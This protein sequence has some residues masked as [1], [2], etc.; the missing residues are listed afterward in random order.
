MNIYSLPAQLHSILPAARIIAVGVFDGVHIGHRT[1]L[2]RALL[3][4]DLTPAVFTFCETGDL[5]SGGY[6]Q[7]DSER[8]AMLKKL[9]FS[10]VFEA[11]FNAIRDMSPKAFVDMLKNDLGAKAIV[12][13]F[14][15]RF[16]KGGVGDIALLQTLC[17][18]ADIRVYVQ[19]AIEADGKAVSSTR[20][21]QAL[22]AGDM[23]TVLRLQGRPFTVNATVKSGQHLGRELGSPTINQWLPENTAL[24]RFGVYASLAIVAGTALPAVTNI[25]VRPTVGSEKPLAETYILDF[26]GDL[27][28]EQVPVQF[29][30]FLRPE[31]KF[32]SVDALK[33]YIEK[34]AADARAVFAPRGGEKPRAILFDFDNTLQDRQIAFHKFIE[35]WVRKH[36]PSMPEAELQ[37]NADMLLDTAQYGFVPYKAVFEK[38]KEILPW[39]TAPDYAEAMTFLKIA[40]P[41]NTTVFE[42]AAETLAQLKK[43]GYLL[44]MLTNGNSRIQNCKLDMSGLRPLFDYILVG[45]DEGIQKPQAEVF[46]RAALRLGVHPTD[47]VYVGDNPV[48]DIEGAIGADMHPI[49]RDF[50]YPGVTVGTPGVPHIHCLKELL[51]MYA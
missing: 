26:D 11:D 44:G 9:E 1:V 49:F 15:F 34:D 12:C 43:R 24:P 35:A 30:C 47:C 45:G 28:G 36:F 42:D 13:G 4:H 21:K 20:I 46:R 33:T 29:V 14:N 48:N 23:E 39:E 22:H 17:D 38:A 5:K 50:E 32:D 16:G 37:Q 31:Q 27:Y 10:D 3:E 40:Y 8:R 19:Q 7:T 6:L 41:F 25:G 18:A 51:D 2:S